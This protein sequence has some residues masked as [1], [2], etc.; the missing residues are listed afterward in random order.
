MACQSLGIHVGCCENAVA[1]KLMNHLFAIFPSHIYN[2]YL[3]S[4]ILS[5]GFVEKYYD[6]ITLACFK[7]LNLK[8]WCIVHCS[9]VMIKNNLNTHTHGKKRRKRERKKA[10]NERRGNRC[11][12]VCVNVCVCMKANLGILSVFFHSL[13]IYGKGSKKETN[14]SK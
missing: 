7:E 4:L 11:M 6:R 14:E 5:F 13:N 12:N 1:S 10:S 3:D 9:I 8:G 2:I